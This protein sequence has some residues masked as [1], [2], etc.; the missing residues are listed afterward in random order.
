M[1]SETRKAL[2]KCLRVRALAPRGC[3]FAA[4]AAGYTITRSTLRWRLTNSPFRNAEVRLIPGQ[5]YGVRTNLSLVIDG[6][7][8]CRNATFNGT[9]TVS[10]TRKVTATSQLTGGTMR[11]VWQQ[12]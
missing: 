11:I 9:C 10:L 5:R 12:R 2:N 8:R 4:S 3:P 7:V 6:S 1:I